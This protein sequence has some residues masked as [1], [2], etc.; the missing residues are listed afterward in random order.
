[1]SYRGYLFMDRLSTTVDI[2]PSL[3][4]ELAERVDGLLA[5]ERLMSVP[6]TSRLLK[7]YRRAYIAPLG[8]GKIL[9]VQFQP[10]ENAGDL[11]DLM[12][13]EQRSPRYLRL[14]FNPEGARPVVAS[15]TAVV[16]ELM[17]DLLPGFSLDWFFAEASITRIDLSFDVYG[18]P[19]AHFRVSGLLRRMHSKRY[20]SGPEGL[21]SIVFGRRT[22]IRGL[23]I[24]DKNL[25]LR[26]AQS[27]V[28]EWPSVRGLYP[29]PSQ[30]RAS[31]CR[32]VLSDAATTTTVRRIRR[33]P[34]ARERV[35]FEFRFKK[36][37]TFADLFALSR[38]FDG[39]LV[40]AYERVDSDVR[41]HVFAWFTHA[42]ENVGLHEA[43]NMIED[44]RERTR[45]RNAIRDLHPPDW[46]N[47]N[48][49]RAELSAAIVRTF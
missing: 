44:Q 15:A 48:A 7:G 6:H 25:Q 14:E 26:N 1:M 37:G 41:G 43:L 13:G 39:Y 8:G 49:I 21:H 11:D 24:Y 20:E 5:Q 34:R 33:T 38:M 32:A 23:T 30:G 17:H 42:V 3:R 27:E 12:Q 47:P 29:P 31:S 4:I 19:I 2:N 18:I 10:K 36:V 35:R 28:F 45:Y 46:W 16:T 40:R 22:S 9:T